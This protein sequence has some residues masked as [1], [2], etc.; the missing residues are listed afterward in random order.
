MKQLTMILALAMFLAVPAANGQKAARPR[1]GSGTVTGIVDRPEKSEGR[2]EYLWVKANGFTY[3]FNIARAKLVGGN[4]STVAAAGTRLIITY[5]KLAHSEMDDFYT[6]DA[7]AVTVQGSG[8]KQPS[9]VQSAKTALATY[10]ASDS[11]SGAGNFDLKIEGKVRSFFWS[12]GTQF[13]NFA[14]HNRAYTVGAEWRITYTEPTNVDADPF[15]LS[16]TYTGRV[17]PTSSIKSGKQPQTPSSSSSEQSLPLSQVESR[18]AASQSAAKPRLGAGEVSGV[19][20][21]GLDQAVTYGPRGQLTGITVK[22][23]QKYQCYFFA[24]PATNVTG[25]RLQKG[26]RVRVTYKNWSPASRI[27]VIFLREMR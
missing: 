18:Q 2:I 27:A 5:Q 25:G 12:K 11:G 10:L 8:A 14:H 22:V 9:S 13:N 6:G 21:D 17:A 20:E 4:L 7:V 19:L 1:A 15:L 26:L 16:A 24:T 23:G 3:F